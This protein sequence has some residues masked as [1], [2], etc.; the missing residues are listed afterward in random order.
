MARCGAV[1]HG[2][3]RVELIYLRTKVKIGSAK[4]RRFNREHILSIF[5]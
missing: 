1:V 2:T 4:L 5:F 3:L